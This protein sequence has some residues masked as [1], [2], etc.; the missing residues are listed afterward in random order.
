MGMVLMT[1][2]GI[3]LQWETN[4]IAGVIF[5]STLVYFLEKDEP[6]TKFTSI[7]AGFWWC[8]VTMTTV[9]YGD[10]VPITLG[11]SST[12]TKREERCFKPANW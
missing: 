10:I 3:S 9:G 12:R 6:G 11:G 2:E 8:I 7:P 5:F 1:G 4:P